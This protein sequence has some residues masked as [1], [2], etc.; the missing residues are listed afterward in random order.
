M[1][2]LMQGERVKERRKIPFV[3]RNVY[4]NNCGVLYPRQAA[5]SDPFGRLRRGICCNAVP[6]TAVEGRC[7]LQSQIDS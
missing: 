1:M 3:K 7:N 5:P 4:H 2:L 6:P